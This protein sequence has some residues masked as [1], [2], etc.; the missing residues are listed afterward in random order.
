PFNAG[1]WALFVALTLAII[2]FDN[3]VSRL[4]RLRLIM[5]NITLLH[6]LLSAGYG[7]LLRADFVH[8]TVPYNPYKSLEALAEGLNQKKVQLM[9]GN[10]HTMIENQLRNSKRSG[11]QMLNVALQNQPIYGSNSLKTELKC[12]KLGINQNRF[13]MLDI[14]NRFRMTCKKQ[15]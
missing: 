10:A 11:W 14:N 2:L 9:V 1:L 6:A 4:A 8:M 15:L 13:A 3:C 12:E 7:A 5:L